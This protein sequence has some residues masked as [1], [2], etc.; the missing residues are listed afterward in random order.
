M[1]P[2]FRMIAAMTKLERIALG[3]FSVLLIGSFFMLLRVFYV[4]N[5][6]IVPVQGGT[7]I[8]GAVGEVQPLNPWFTITNDVN[9]DLVSLIFSGLLRYDPQ[10]GQIVDDL[11]T[12]KVSEDNRIYTLT[13]KPDIFWH[14]TTD[15]K[16]HPVTAD[17]VM[18]TYQTI[19]DPQ[20][21]NTILQQNFRGVQIDKLDEHTVRFSLS[22]PYSFFRSNLTLGLLP[23]NY[24]EGIPVS[25]IDQTID[26]GLHPIGSGPYEFISLQQTDFSTEV[27]LKRFARPSLPVVRID[28]IVMRVFLDYNTLLSDIMNVN[29][30]R[31]VAHDDKG[32]PI[33]PHQLQPVSYTLPQ[34]VALFF[35]L[36]REIISDKM[37][38]TGLQLATN[39]QQIADALHETNIVDTPLAEIDLKDWHYKFDPKAAQGALFASKWNM[40]EKLRLQ[41]LL[42]RRNTNS[43]G[44]LR[45]MPPVVLMDTG[46]VLTLTGS[47]TG[48]EGGHALINGIPLHS[49][50]TLVSGQPATATGT[51]VVRL[52]S[53]KTSSGALKQGVSLL[54]MTSLDGKV[55]D[56]GYIERITD[57][58]RY[59]LAQ[60]EQNLV[61][62]YLRS[63]NGSTPVAQ[64]I[65]ID[66]LYLD[67]T[68]YL[69]TKQAQDLPHTRRNLQGKPLSLVLL[70]S[71]TPETYRTVA[72]NI[73]K[74]WQAVGVDVKIEIPK[75]KKE[76]EQR[77]LTRN[78]DILLF[79]QSLLDNL[80]SYPYW[81]SSQIQ[82]RDMKNLKQDAFNLSQ[83]ASFE[84][85]ALLNR[86]RE[87]NSAE[88][89]VQDLL[90]LNNMIKRDVPA[91]FLYSP[92]YVTAY[93]EDTQGRMLGKLALHSDRLTNVNQ[94]YIA[95]ERQFKQGKNWL[96][97]FHWLVS[98][99]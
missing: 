65:D 89:R 29:G 3:V 57:Q 60:E 94:W 36:D 10:K 12:L 32:K 23:K 78:Y 11:A 67:A 84:A 64:R 24:F 73:Q 68:G 13:L 35:N 59:R 44:P 90:T 43:V 14:D 61:D 20:F 54:K 7:Y 80:D 66:S 47:L 76:F 4:Q 93:D 69:R 6:E 41:A 92:I 63:K 62:R 25:K 91:I 31:L 26:F 39:K 74:Q 48:I 85:D 70:T 40:P 51:W 95:T 15:K 27:T 45:N 87:T 38:R 83:Y 56:S 30:V 75:T 55:I 81:H 79:G 58:N 71:S 18:F 28:R 9:R 17:D 50:A 16:P 42:E 22:K 86:I 72:E 5:S 33:L 98:L 97:F 37:L 88:R 8:E 82:D 53:A 49:G 99:F 19:Q 52:P 46:A 2:L 21:P 77:M 96:S 1:Q 34:Y